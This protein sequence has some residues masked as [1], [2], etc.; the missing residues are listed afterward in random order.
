MIFWMI[1]YSYY[2]H[3]HLPSCDFLFLGVHSKVS[4]DFS[5]DGD[6]LMILVALDSLELTD[7]IDT[8][9]S[10]FC[11]ILDNFLGASMVSLGR[12]VRRCFC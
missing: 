6:A 9:L 12:L 3:C 5:I 7:P 4:L 8:C 10:C 2:H 11:F 1:F